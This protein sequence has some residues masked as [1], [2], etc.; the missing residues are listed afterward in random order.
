[1]VYSDLSAT[2]S[3]GQSDLSVTDSYG[4]LKENIY[5]YILVHILKTAL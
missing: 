4:L 5:W 1:M 3:Y 2:D